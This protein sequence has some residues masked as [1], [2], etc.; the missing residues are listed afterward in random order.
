M[1]TIRYA[2][3]AKL[4]KN[5]PIIQMDPREEVSSYEK[6]E[7]QSPLPSLLPPWLLPG[8]KLLSH[9]LPFYR[10]VDFVTQKRAEILS[11]RE[12]DFEK[13]DWK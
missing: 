9:R 6:N 5:K 8:D 4:I 12:F 10:L 1:K 13:G 3:R 11:R 2:D 7:I